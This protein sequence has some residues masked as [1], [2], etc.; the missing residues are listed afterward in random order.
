MVL[1][2]VVLVLSAQGGNEQL[3]AAVLGFALPV[4]VYTFYL[5][6]VKG[7]KDPWRLE[8]KFR[9]V[10]IACNMAGILALLALNPSTNLEFLL[11]YIVMLNLFVFA[12]TLFFKIS[13]H[14]TGVASTGVWLL[15][16]YSQTLQEAGLAEGAPLLS[17]TL[18]MLVMWA[19]LRL[20]AHT[21]QE[22]FAGS[23]AGTLLPLIYAFLLAPLLGQ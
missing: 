14:A 20:R 9:F 15:L 7:H 5:V 3:L 4:V 17:L 11:T 1:Q 18:L 16:V 21:P 13:L 6:R 19:R 10:P 23:L 12:V 2:L 8:R 22:V